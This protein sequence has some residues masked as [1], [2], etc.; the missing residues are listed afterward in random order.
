MEGVG[1]SVG[2]QAARK[3]AYAS[4]SHVRS[5]GPGVSAAMQRRRAAA[6]V[7]AVKG[8]NKIRDAKY[9]KKSKNKNE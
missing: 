2:S 8:Y 1:R 7:A 3:A 4:G 6:S 9:E 5:A